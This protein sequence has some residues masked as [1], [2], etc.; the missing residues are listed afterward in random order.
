[1]EEEREQPH[2]HLDKYQKID[3][4]LLHLILHID[5]P[6]SQSCGVNQLQMAARAADLTNTSLGAPVVCAFSQADVKR[7]G[8]RRSVSTQSDAAGIVLQFQIKRHRLV[9]VEVPK[10]ERRW[11]VHSET[12]RLELHIHSRP[13]DTTWF[14]S[15]FA[16]TMLPGSMLAV[17]LEGQTVTASSE[18]K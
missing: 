11:V 8:R 15:I 5:W 2:L 18:G 10:A 1:M 9:A 3:R 6:S 13:A 14:E 16:S 4:E 7:K 12:P 17:P